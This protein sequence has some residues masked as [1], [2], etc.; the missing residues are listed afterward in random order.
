MQPLKILIIDVFSCLSITC[1]NG[2]DICIAF[3]FIR[4]SFATNLLE[5]LFTLSLCRDILKCK[6]NFCKGARR[7]QGTIGKNISHPRY[8]LN[9]LFFAFSNDE[10]HLN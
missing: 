10:K 4:F 3:Y 9:C 5:N 8:V 7:K 2:D 6:A 1:L